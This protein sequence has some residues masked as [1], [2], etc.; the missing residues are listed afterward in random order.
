V[1]S[2]VIRV[3]WF[4]G[5]RDGEW[6]VWDGSSNEILIPEA[7]LI[8]IGSDDLGMSERRVPL[9]RHPDNPRYY[10]AHWNEAT[11]R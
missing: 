3:Q 1:R 5:P 10:L 6:F 2:K 8:Q 4:G 11:T 9:R 7:D